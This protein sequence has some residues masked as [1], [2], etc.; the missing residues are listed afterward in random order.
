MCRLIVLVGIV[1]MAGAAAAAATSGS[2]PE[3][4]RRNLNTPAGNLKTLKARVSYQASAFPIA[5]RMTPPSGTW[6]G[7]QWKTNSHGKPAFGWAAVGHP[8]LDNPLGD[9]WIET[10]YGPTP[11]VAA[12]IA[13]LR[14]GGSHLPDTHIGGVTFGEPSPVKLAGFSGR[15]YRSFSRAQGSPGQRGIDRRARRRCPSE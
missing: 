1:A 12:A 8:P 5:L 2:P 9:I 15:R 7:A 4:P 3:L 10:A 11:S 14:T 6:G 13:R